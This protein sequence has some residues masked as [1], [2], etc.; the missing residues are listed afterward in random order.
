[1]PPPS[2]KQLEARLGFNFQ[3]GISRDP[4]AKR[5]PATFQL[6]Q[7]VD[8]IS[9]R[10]IS[11]GITRIRKSEGI[12]RRTREILE[13]LGPTLWPDLNETG[14]RDSS[15]LLGPFDDSDPH[16]Y[17]EYPKDL[18]FSDPIDRVT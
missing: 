12:K 6:L 14:E 11:Y 4:R 7:R 2:A 18:M 5:T 15:W 10:Y 16:G 9:T 8:E 3:L 13:D 1:M 17:T